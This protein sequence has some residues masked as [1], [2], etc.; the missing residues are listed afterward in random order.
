MM[1]RIRITLLALA[2]FLAGCA[3]A[4]R[5]LDTGAAYSTDSI[6]L[7]AH[8]V[9]D[10]LQFTTRADQPREILLDM[11]LIPG[12]LAGSI[13]TGP[14]ISRKA[15]IGETVTIDL[16]R[17][18]ATVAKYAT[19]LLSTKFNHGL[20]ISPQSRKLVRVGTFARDPQT[21]RFLGPTGVLDPQA[22]TKM[23]LMLVY[24]DGPAVV[25]G[26]G[27]EG[28]KHIAYHVEVKERG[29]VWLEINQVAP[30]AMIITN[31]QREGG[32]V[33]TV[34]PPRKVETKA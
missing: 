29:F 20:S 32:A 25:T 10:D 28:N 13:L 23:P 3:T 21:G 34:K 9:D 31:R 30:D 5:D 6:T 26:I 24:F 18:Q 27:M 33:L 16:S 7:T 17:Y 1:I 4:P 19:P 22:P 11:P 2:A 15:R 12:A 14:V 8:Y